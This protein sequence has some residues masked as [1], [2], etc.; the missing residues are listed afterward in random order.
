MGTRKNI[1]IEKGW[2]AFVQDSKCLG[3]REFK[4][5][6]KAF[7]SLEIITKPTEAELKTELKD[8]KISLP[9]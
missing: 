3:I 6:G 4:E 1:I 7:T 2:S 8:R 9:Q 5:G